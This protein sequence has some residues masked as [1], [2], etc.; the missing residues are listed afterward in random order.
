MNIKVFPIEKL[1]LVG[2]TATLLS[3]VAVAQSRQPVD[4]MSPFAKLTGQLSQTPG[5]S[6]F[7]NAFIVG[8]DGCHILTNF[9]VAFGK[10]KDPKTGE[11]KFVDNI[12]VGHTVYFA[13]DLDARTGKFQRT[14]KAKVVEY[15]DYEAGTAPGMLGDIALLRLETCLG[16][17]YAGIEIDRPAPGKRVP[18]GELMTI[19]SSRDAS[20]KNEVLVEEGCHALPFTAVTGIILASCESVPG[21]SGAMILELGEDQKWRLAGM[22]IGR[23]TG[24]GKQPSKV[25]YASAINKF[26]DGIQI[27]QAPR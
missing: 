12:D 22:N 21:M 16:P 6:A 23:S 2:I 20:G 4:P 24:G 18:T 5:S 25:L 14:M 1:L 27:A 9:H 19:S 3:V 13:F 8:Q 10:S 17:K 11:I 7:G 26:L 15:G